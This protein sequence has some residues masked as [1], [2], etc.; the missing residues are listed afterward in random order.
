M[1]GAPGYSRE[2]PTLVGALPVWSAPLQPRNSTSS[3]SQSSIE[4]LFVGLT[5]LFVTVIV[6]PV[7][8]S[9]TP[10]SDGPP[11]FV[12]RKAMT[13]VLAVANAL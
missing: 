10:R 1:A 5:L 3:V 12:T 9:C 4:T 13:W 7:V 8:Q 6:Y 11:V 2:T